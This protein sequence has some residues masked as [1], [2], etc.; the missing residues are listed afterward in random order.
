MKAYTNTFMGK[1]RREQG[2]ERTEVLIK[3]YKT[4][5]K[6]GRQAARDELRERAKLGNDKAKS[7]L[8]TNFKPKQKRKGNMFGFGSSNLAKDFGF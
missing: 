6:E 3:K 2:K 4:F 8:K 7:F 1:I 5:N